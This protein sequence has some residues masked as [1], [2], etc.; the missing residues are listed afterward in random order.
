M[1]SVNDVKVSKKTIDLG[2]GVE[3]EVLF[4]LNA[5]ADLEEKYG[6]IEEAF[7]KV[8]NGSI[9]AIRFL[10]WCVLVPD[11]DADLTERE[12]G[13]LINISNLNDIMDALMGIFEEHMP[14]TDNSAAG[15]ADPKLVVAPAV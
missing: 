5:M 1:A 12:I 3:R 14:A 7:N 9:S 10:L 15:T 6:S 11:G 2:D 4:S 8:Q 13:K